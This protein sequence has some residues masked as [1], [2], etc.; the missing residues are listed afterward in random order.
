MFCPPNLHTRLDAIY[1]SLDQDEIEV[2][3]EAATTHA[4]EP[5]ALRMELGRLVAMA[6]RRIIYDALE[7]CG[8]G[9]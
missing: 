5:G 2:M 7:G 6:E 9:A 3:L 4:G 1:D 8:L